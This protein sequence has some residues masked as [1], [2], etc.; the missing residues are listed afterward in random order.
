MLLRATLCLLMLGCG[1]V[2]TALAEEADGIVGQWWT[3]ESDA[4]FEILKQEGR[5]FGKIAW[6]KDPLYPGEDKEAGRT[7]HDRKN[8]D[9]SKRDQPLVGLLLL[10][11]FEYKGSNNWSSGTI[12]NPENGKTYDAKLHLEN[13]DTLKVRGYIGISLIGGTTVWTRYEEPAKPA[14]EKKPEPSK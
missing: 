1:A 10:K 4:R 8:P 12:Y 5:Y 3:E 7:K 13:K 2:R 6:L 9:P 14:E 11:D